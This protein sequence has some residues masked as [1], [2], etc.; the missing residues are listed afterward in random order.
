MSEFALEVEN[1]VKVYASRGKAPIRA[2][3]G[4]SFRVPRGI[5]FGLLGP[6]GA[7]KSSLLRMLSTLTRP[8][9]GTAKILGYDVVKRP[10]EVRKRISSVIQATAVELFLSVKDNLLTYARF[11]GLDKAAAARRADAL[12]EEFQLG[13]EIDRKVQDLSGGFRRRVQVAKVFMVDRPVLFLDEFST[14]MDPILKR[15]VM[16]LL[17][18]EV[19]K[20]RTIILTTQVLNE[21]EELCDDILIINRGKQVARGDLNTLKQLSRGVYDITLAFDRLPDTIQAEIAA[22]TP[23]RFIVEGNTIE[24]TLKI[25]EHRVMDVVS[26]LS[27]NR[28]VLRVEVRGA[29][30]EDIFVELTTREGKVVA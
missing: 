11:Q 2:V 5:I 10:I 13:T 27:R 12:I 6:N 4:M 23:I 24:L 25:E 1:L 17:R 21:A 15:Q 3:D 29:S 20:E 14:G 30:L 16:N 8:T 19:E 28:H 9:E 26:A 7:G 22:L 18:T